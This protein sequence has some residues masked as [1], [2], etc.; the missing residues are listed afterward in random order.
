MASPGSSPT[1]PDDS[2]PLAISYQEAIR[3]ET[4]ILYT[5]TPCNP[6]MR[7]VPKYNV[8]YYFICYAHTR[9]HLSAFFLCLTRGL[10]PPFGFLAQ[11]D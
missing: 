4:R 1:A 7:C 9:A 10:L 2:V 8:A 3:P 6:T 11:P 5:E